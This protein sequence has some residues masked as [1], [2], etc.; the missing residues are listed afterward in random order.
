MEQVAAVSLLLYSPLH[1]PGL[2]SKGP[3]QRQFLGERQDFVF[4]L[5]AKIQI[6]RKKRDSH[7]C[8]S[9]NVTQFEKKGRTDFRSEGRQ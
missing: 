2:V 1:S 4:V 6:F 9:F 5:V 8:E 7:P 3:Q